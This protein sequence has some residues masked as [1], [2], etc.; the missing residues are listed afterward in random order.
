MV[1]RIKLVPAL[2][3]LKAGESLRLSQ[4][5]TT[6]NTADRYFVNR[7]G[8]LSQ[9]YAGTLANLLIMESSTTSWARY[10]EEYGTLLAQNFD[11]DIP[12]KRFWEIV[13]GDKV[14][15]ANLDELSEFCAC[16]I[17]S[18]RAECQQLAS[19]QIAQLMFV[20]LLRAHLAA[21]GAFP[22]GW[23]RALGDSRLAP[24]LRLMH[25]APE[26]DWKLEALASACAMSRT[27]FSVRFKASVG[28]TPFAYLIEWR[29]RLAER[30]LRESDLSVA[31]VG[32]SL[33][34]TSESAF[35]HA[36]KRVVGR[37]PRSYRA[38]P[39][40]CVTEK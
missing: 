23:L 18:S 7:L 17:P 10:S 8:G 2:A 11:T 3:R 26:R 28:R 4:Y 37:A 38:S 21:S 9:Y 22:V 35:S 25:Q 13:E 32:Q 6:E 34:Y 20:E 31:G 15:Q 14:T 39:D 19:S 29:M 36:F 30:A 16:N 12:G 27:T 33:G 24:S 5:A 40:A 1:G